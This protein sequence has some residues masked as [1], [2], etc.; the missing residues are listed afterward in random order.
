MKPD[1]VENRIAC[2]TK[3][4][5]AAWLAFA[6]D[7]SESRAVFLSR[8]AA[9]EAAKKYGWFVAELWAK[10]TLATEERD[11][12]EEL[13]NAAEGFFKAFEDVTEARRDCREAE[14]IWQV[15]QIRE[16]RLSDAKVRFVD[17]LRLLLDRLS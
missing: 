5:P 7:G 17:S 9:D 1:E 10:P 2:D 16:K 14:G 6:C 3:N 8:E 13:S 11:M 4:E 15:E 12:G